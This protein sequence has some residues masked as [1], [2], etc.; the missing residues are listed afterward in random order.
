MR[1]KKREIGI[2]VVLKYANCGGN[3]QATAFR[4]PAKQKAQAVAWKSKAKKAYNREERE[5]SVESLK[6]REIP[7][8]SKDK[9][10]LGESHEDRKSSVESQNE[11]EAIPQLVEIE[12]DISTNWA[13][14]LEEKSS[15]LSSAGK[16]GP[17]NVGKW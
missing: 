17:K 5:T 14:S 13:G 8:E 12:L 2:Y 1:G 16:G 7:I 11:E 9:E 6:D 4:C 10:I 3:H 15:D